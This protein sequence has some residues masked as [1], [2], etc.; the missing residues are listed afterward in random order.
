MAKMISCFEACFQATA[1][2]RVYF[3]LRRSKPSNMGRDIQIKTTCDNYIVEKIYFTLF[4]ANWRYFPN[5]KK[6]YRQFLQI[7]LPLT[8]CTFLLTFFFTEQIGVCTSYPFPTFMGSYYWGDRFLL[9]NKDS[10]ISA[11]LSFCV[12]SSMPSLHLSFI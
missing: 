5:I 9:G 3:V 6:W 4:V 10:I 8:V 7:A 1:F 2:L 12:I 11:C